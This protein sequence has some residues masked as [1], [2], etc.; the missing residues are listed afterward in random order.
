MSERGIPALLG[1]LDPERGVGVGLESLAGLREEGGGN[2]GRGLIEH[3]LELLAARL[4]LCPLQELGVRGPRCRPN[5]PPRS[6]PATGIQVS[7]S[8]W[9]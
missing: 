3:I 9:I 2:S 1:F 5:R 8:P 4:R 6:L 7:G